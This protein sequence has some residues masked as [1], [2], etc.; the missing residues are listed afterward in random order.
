VPLWHA[1]NPGFGDQVPGTQL[2]QSQRRPD[3]RH[4]GRADIEA[5][6]RGLAWCIAVIAALTLPEG[7]RQ[8]AVTVAVV[9]A[10]G[11]LWWVLVLRRRLNAGTAGPPGQVV[12]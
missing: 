5:T 11:F 2:L 3:D 9:L 12:L 10:I 6:R 8:N 4:V 7:N 1:G